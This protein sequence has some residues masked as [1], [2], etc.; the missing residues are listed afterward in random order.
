MAKQP[1]DLI[2]TAPVPPEQGGYPGF[3][4]RTEK[5]RGMV[6][7]YDVAVPMRDGVVIYVD[8]YRPDLPGTYPAADRLGPLRQARAHPLR[9]S[10]ATPGSTTR[11]STSSPGSRRPTRSTG[12]PTASRSS[13]PTPG[14]PGRREGDLTWMSEQEVEDM[15][16]LIEWAGTR[17]WSNGKVGMHGVSYLAWSQWKVAAANP[18]HLAAINPWEGVSDFYRE[19]FFHGGIPETLFC[20]M[21]QKQRPL[22]QHPGRGPSG[23]AEAASSLR[24]VLGRQERRPLQDNRA[25][26]RGGLL[27]RPRA[28]Q[29]GDHRGVQA[30]LVQGQMADRPRAQEVVAFLPARERGEAAAVLQPIPQRHRQPREG[31]AEGD[32]RGPGEVL[33]RRDPHRERVAARADPVHQVLPQRGDRE[34][35]HDPSG[36]RVGGGVQR[37][38]RLRHER[39]RQRVLPVLPGGGRRVRAAD[40]PGGRAGRPARTESREAP[41]PSGPRSRWSSPRGPSSPAT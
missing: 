28:A 35:R 1:D 27:D 10:W 15:Y 18:P 9:T 17:E 24:R 3:H 25:R 34:P 23:H 7:E 32:H 8:V 37:G 20:A 22:L 41:K 2:F 16:D 12:A 30:D 26:L 21:W 40:P 11:T 13:T 39:G 19:L 31:L 4:P 14:A 6:I 5:T 33:R 29:P 38:S 36:V